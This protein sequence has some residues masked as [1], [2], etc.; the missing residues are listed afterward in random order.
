MHNG[1]NSGYSH[2]NSKNQQP[3]PLPRKPSSQSDSDNRSLNK[4]SSGSSKSKEK[5]GG[6]WSKL[7]GKKG[8]TKSKKLEEPEVEISSPF[9]VNHTIHVDFNS[10][11]GFRGLPREWE[12]MLGSSGITKDDVVQNSDV[13]LDVLEFQSNYEKNKQEEEGAKKAP[14]PLP[15]QQN[16]ILDHFL[17]KSIDPATHFKDMKKIGEGAAGEVYLATETQS[18]RRIAIKK[19]PL[20]AQNMKLLVNEIDIMKS[21]K[22]PNVTEYIDCFI[23]DDKLWVTM[24][25]MNGGCLTEVL[26]QFENVQ[27]TEEQIALC[28]LETLK[29]LAYIHR[30]H[31]IH[32]DIK[33]DNILLN[34]K[35]EVK[36]ADFG[37][38]AQLTQQREKRTTIV[39]TPYWMA[40]ELIRGQK[41]DQKVD[42]WSLGIMV[43][44]MAEGEP[45][46]MEFPPLRAL[47]LITTKGIPG[48]KQPDIWSSEFSDFISQCL[49]KDPVE[50][51][52]AEVLLK[53]PYLKKA[54]NPEELGQVIQAAR[55]HKEAANRLPDLF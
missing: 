54:C 9:D 27:M 48:L 29:G 30:L 55:R 11:T 45:P 13:V 16:L 52:D 46:Y 26:E 49:K 40:P 42:L 38:A 37:Y 6:F 20:N 28:C 39:G 14:T 50:R 23:V 10:K 43:M 17:N 12:A 24:E 2:S 44:E 53:H 8:K 41:Y 34:L 19:M 1:S 31:R 15:Q 33:S 22:H 35:G 5:G 32:R 36:L 51:P 7:L 4:S 21:S 18:G 47:F 3:P 25:Y